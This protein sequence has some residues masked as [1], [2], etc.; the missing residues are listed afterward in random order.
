MKKQLSFIF[1]SLMLA[2]CQA[3]S[4]VSP[5]QP[6]NPIELTASQRSIVEA[7]VREGLKDPFSAVVGTVIAGKR[8]RNGVE[9][10]VACGYVNAKNSFGAYI[11]FKPFVGHLIGNSFKVIGSGDGSSNASSMIGGVCRTVGLPILDHPAQSSAT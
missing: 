10:T 6:V 7:G 9:E 11:G 1:V 2:S 8:I 5:P 3:A 4:S